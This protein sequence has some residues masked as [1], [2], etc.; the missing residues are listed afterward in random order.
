MCRKCY[1]DIDPLIG[2]EPAAPYRDEA[3][4][5]TAT[6]VEGWDS[7]REWARQFTAKQ[8]ASTS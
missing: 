6:K 7:Y 3:D 5:I 2:G 1:R 8:F 4:N